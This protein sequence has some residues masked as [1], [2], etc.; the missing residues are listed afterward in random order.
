MYK[1][2]ICRICLLEV[3][4]TFPFYQQIPYSLP[5]EHMN[6]EFLHLLCSFPFPISVLSASSCALTVR[7][8]P[9]GACTWCRVDVPILLLVA[10]GAAQALGAW[11]V[12]EKAFPPYAG[13]VP[14][15]GWSKQLE[16]KEEMVKTAPFCC[17][18]SVWL[19]AL[20]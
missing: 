11:L 19:L 15:L 13:V 6:S 17:G 3:F 14:V 7:D 2:E 20:N 16:E 10:I 4:L 12:G 18:C 8:G 1:P 9:G 5:R